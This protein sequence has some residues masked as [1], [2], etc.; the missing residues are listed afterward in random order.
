MKLSRFKN[1]WRGRQRTFGLRNTIFVDEC[2]GNSSSVLVLSMGRWLNGG[3]LS[4]G[5]E[6]G[7]LNDIE[8]KHNN[9]KCPA[10]S[11]PYLYVEDAVLR[12][13]IRAQIPLI[14]LHQ[15]RAA[16]ANEPI[17]QQQYGA[18]DSKMN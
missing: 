6:D 12:D 18:R 10:S 15:I 14:Y 13:K 11:L 2:W 9:E 5:D 3:R 4:I 16:S 17:F 1:E 7:M 8:L